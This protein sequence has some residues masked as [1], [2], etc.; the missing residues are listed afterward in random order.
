MKRILIL[1]LFVAIGTAAL[2]NED[3]GT[4]KEAKARQKDPSYSV[5]N[6]KHAD[7]AEWSAKHKKQESE[8]TNFEVRTADSKHSFTRR[9]GKKAVISSYSGT[10]SPAASHKHPLSK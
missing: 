6:Y 1:T 4:G 8:L 7:K 3:P 10:S 9:S 2:A 5:H